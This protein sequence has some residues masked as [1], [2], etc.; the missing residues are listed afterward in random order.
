[1]KG[2]KEQVVDPEVVTKPLQNRE[3][4]K[5]ESRIM[6]QEASLHGGVQQHVLIPHGTHTLD[7]I[8]LP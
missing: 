6:S 4:N 3:E 1:M 2:E 5:Q 8:P 7:Q